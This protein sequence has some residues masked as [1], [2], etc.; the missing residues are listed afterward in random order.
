M[1]ATVTR[2]KTPSYYA[3]LKG[4]QY[5]CTGLI[6]P[7]Q[8]GEYTQPTQWP[9]FS[10]ERP[11]RIVWNAIAATLHKRGWSDKQIRE[12]LQSKET[13]WALDGSLG[14]ALK[15]TATKWAQ[16]NSPAKLGRVEV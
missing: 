15:E 9:M 5:D 6:G 1:P 3:K 12:W 13:R 16:E 11:A 2:Q 7:M 4:G 8:H 14:D 10:F